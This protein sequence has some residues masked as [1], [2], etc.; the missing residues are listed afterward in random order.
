MLGVEA[1]PIGRGT[2][3]ATIV[4]AGSAPSGA[5]IVAAAGTPTPGTIVA[6]GAGTREVGMTAEPWKVAAAAATMDDRL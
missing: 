3:R 4:A 5:T 6:A 2:S 1:I